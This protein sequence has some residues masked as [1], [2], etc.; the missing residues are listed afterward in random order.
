MILKLKHVIFFQAPPS[1][2]SFRLTISRGLGVP[3][4]QLGFP[5]PKS[6]SFRGNLHQLVNLQ[7]SVSPFSC[8]SRTSLK[9]FIIMDTK[10]PLCNKDKFYLNFKIHRPYVI[11]IMHHLQRLSSSSFKFALDTLLPTCYT[12]KKNQYYNACLY[13]DHQIMGSSITTWIIHD[14]KSHLGFLL[15]FLPIAALT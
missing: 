15:L 4:T 5:Q 11:T 13:I 7:I 1:L 8:S 10:L 2:V 3:L 9:E 14:T 12:I 6:A